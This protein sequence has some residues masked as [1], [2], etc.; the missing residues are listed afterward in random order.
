MAA[1]GTRWVDRSALLS[2]SAPPTRIRLAT[3][4]ASFR[5]SSVYSCSVLLMNVEIFTPAILQW[6]FIASITLSG[7]V[8]FVGVVVGFMVFPM[9]WVFIIGVIFICVNTNTKV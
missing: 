3:A 7:S 2:T 1:E 9:D 8:K 4:F 5:R 6:V